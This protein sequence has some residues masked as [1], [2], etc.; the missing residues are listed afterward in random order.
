MSRGRKGA[1]DARRSRARL[2]VSSRRGDFLMN[3]NHCRHRLFS[4]ASSAP[5]T[6]LLFVGALLVGS[7]GH[8]A[9]PGDSLP[10]HYHLPNEKDSKIVSVTPGGNPQA[11]VVVV[12][13]AMSIQETGPK[14]TVDTFGEVYSFSPSFIAVQ[15]EEPTMLTFWN[16]QPDDDHD[17]ALLDPNW[18]VLM[19]V[20]LPP[21]KKTS[22]LFT[23]HK[24]GLFSFKCMQHSPAMSGQ[25]LVLPPGSS[26]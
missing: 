20:D 14:E 21:L 1:A 17:F 6:I 3:D 9:G 26:N 22:Y 5:W 25:I 2:L 18:R 23:F 7:S 15:R 12:T 4:P 10:H 8:A 11:E 19:Y 13:G 24:T 16:L